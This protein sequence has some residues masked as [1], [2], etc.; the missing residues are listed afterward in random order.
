MKDKCRR[1]GLGALVRKCSVT[2]SS[3]SIDFTTHEWNSAEQ[4]RN[5]ADDIAEVIAEWIAMRWRA[6]QSRA[7]T[8]LVVVI[9]RQLA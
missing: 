9:V 2:S 3:G 4:K 1:G 7:A 5:A 6:E 8:G